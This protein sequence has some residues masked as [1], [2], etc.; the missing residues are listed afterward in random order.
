MDIV[1]RIQDIM[2]KKG[3][4]T[5][6]LE[7]LAGL[8]NGTIRRWNNNYPSCDKIAKIADILNVSTDWLIT[9]KD[10]TLKPEEEELLTTYREISERDRKILLT[11]ARSML[12][13]ATPEAQQDLLSD[14]RAG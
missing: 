3:L 11:M 12:P 4:N 7:E 1:N 13:E 2:I 8:G 5:K 14:S 10:S 9:G 6:K